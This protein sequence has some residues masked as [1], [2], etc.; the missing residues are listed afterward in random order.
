[1]DVEISRAHVIYS[2]YITIILP[3]LAEAVLTNKHLYFY[4]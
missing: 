1:M 2:T 3:L 4:S